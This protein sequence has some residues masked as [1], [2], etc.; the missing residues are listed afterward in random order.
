MWFGR[1]GALAAFRHGMFCWTMLNDIATV[2][3]KGEMGMIV[4]QRSDDQLGWNQGLLWASVAA[5]VSYLIPVMLHLSGPAIIAWKGL[6][7][8]LL[9]LYAVGRASSRDGWLLAVV[10]ALGAAGD[11]VLDIQFTLGAGLFALGHVVAVL[12]YWQNRRT[13]G[14]RQAGIALLLLVLVPAISWMLTQRPDVLFYAALLGAMAAAAWQSH[15]SRARVGLG[16]IL[17]AVSDLLIFARFGPLQSALWVGPA[18][19]ALYYAGQYTIA[20]GVTQALA[21]RDRA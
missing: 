13:P 8:G 18:I 17:F 7:V 20:T 14:Q 1:R 9:A 15:F 12:L 10:L 4:K 5:G 2:K 3:V 11:V 19:W 6:G 16:A 21:R